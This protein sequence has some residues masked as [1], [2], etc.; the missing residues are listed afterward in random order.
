MYFID[1]SCSHR[2]IKEGDNKNLYL[3]LIKSSCGTA[4]AVLR[5][6]N[7]LTDTLIKY[8][9][10]L[11]PCDLHASNAIVKENQCAIT[12]H[13]EG[14]KMYHADSDAAVDVYHMVENK[15]GKM[16]LVRVRCN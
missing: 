14:T 16:K 6:W 15:F 2:V 11:N 4:K 3:V 9:F 12:W 13:V 7:L 10:K 8:G 1:E 5:W